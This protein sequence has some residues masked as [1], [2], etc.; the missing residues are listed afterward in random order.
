MLV[1][2]NEAVDWLIIQTDDKLYDIKMHILDIIFSLINI[3]KG[4]ISFGVSIYTF[5]PSNIESKCLLV[6]LPRLCAFAVKTF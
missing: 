3:L 4:S 6:D 2:S 1:S 5:V